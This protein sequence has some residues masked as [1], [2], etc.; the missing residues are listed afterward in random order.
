MPKCNGR[1]K[2]NLNNE[3]FEIITKVIHILHDYITFD[4]FEKY[5]EEKKLKNLNFK[6][7]KKL[8]IM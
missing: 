1:G 4:Q 6:D 2:L 7:N 3:K 8:H 5:Y